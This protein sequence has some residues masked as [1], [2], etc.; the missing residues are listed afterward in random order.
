MAA[1]DAVKCPRCG[2]ANVQTYYG[3]CS[4]CADELRAKY[5]TEN[6]FVTQYEAQAEAAERKRKEQLDE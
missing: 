6:N 5:D 2:S 3:P 1:M 4:N